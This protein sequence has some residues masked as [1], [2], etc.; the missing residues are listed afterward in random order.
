M[1]FCTICLCQNVVMP[2]KVTWRK[3]FN[4]FSTSWK[5][6]ADGR[7]FLCLHDAVSVSRGQY[8]LQLLTLAVVSERAFRR[9]CHACLYGTIAFCPVFSKNFNIMSTLF[10]HQ[11]LTL[12]QKIDS[13]EGSFWCKKGL[14]V[15]AGKMNFYLNRP[16]LTPV[17]WRF[18]A[19]CSAFCC[20][21]QCN[22]PLNAVR[23]GAKCKVK[24]C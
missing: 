4:V 16:P 9:R 18:A 10:V 15:Y 1:K 2:Q 17:F 22:M 12:S 6:V 11:P 3:L 8:A 21:T 5:L 20:K 13:R 7:L 19:K 14:V 24:W 23:F